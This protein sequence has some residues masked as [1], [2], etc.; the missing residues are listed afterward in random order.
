[1]EIIFS[2]HSKQRMKLYNISDKIIQEIVTE[3]PIQKPGKHEIIKKVE[4]FRYPI[5]VIFK[6]EN[7]S[8]FIISAY[9]IKRGIS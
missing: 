6:K 1:M 9:P 7:E 2:R 4:G 5:K 8:I 3:K